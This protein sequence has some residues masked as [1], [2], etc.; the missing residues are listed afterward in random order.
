MLEIV[1]TLLEHPD[2]AP[3]LALIVDGI[4]NA[5][6][7]AGCVL[8]DGVPRVRQRVIA[9]TPEVPRIPVNVVLNQRLP[10]HPLMEY[11][12][13]TGDLTTFSVDDIAG[14]DWHTSP[15]YTVVRDLVGISR[16]RC[17]RQLSLPLH[18]PPRVARSYFVYRAGMEFDDRE[19]AFARRIQPVLQRLDCHMRIFEQYRRGQPSP[20]TSGVELTPRELTV[21]A[22]LGEGLTASAIGRQLK[23][24][25]STVNT[26]LEHLYRKLGTDNRMT[27]VLR[28]RDLG[29]FPTWLTEAV[30]S[31]SRR[32][33]RPTG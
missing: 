32:R 29:L 16:R 31:G 22:L 8:T 33:E 13:R 27:T 19:R 2:P 12:S 14:S 10:P 20:I 25:V 6:A 21:L 30:A 7:G 24:T 17:M 9:S 5:F 1:F 3:E 23:I 4:C 26:H 28:A 18:A 11:Y 15:A